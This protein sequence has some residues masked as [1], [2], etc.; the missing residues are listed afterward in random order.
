MLHKL[1]LLF[2]FVPVVAFANG[3]TGL[4]NISNANLQ[5]IS[6]PGQQIAYLYA[7]VTGG[8]CTN[9]NAAQLTMDSTNPLGSAMYATL[10]AAKTTG[11]A[12]DIATQGC[13]SSGYPIIISIYLES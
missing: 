8:G 7:P 9:A 12:V 3:D 11:K 6:Y 4:I 10:L 1:A 2:L 5:I 13:N